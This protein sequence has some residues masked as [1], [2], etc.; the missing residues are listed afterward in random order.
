MFNKPGAVFT[1]IPI[2][3]LVLNLGFLSSKCVRKFVLKKLVLTKH[4]S[5]ILVLTIVIN[6]YLFMP[7]TSFVTQKSR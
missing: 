7:Y 5:L 3:I 2:L 4:H 1:N 6:N